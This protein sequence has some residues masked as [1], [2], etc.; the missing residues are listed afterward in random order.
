MSVTQENSKK[1]NIISAP[2]ISRYIR[3]LQS[4][5]TEEN[6]YMAPA[7]DEYSLYAQLRLLKTKMLKK[8]AIRSLAKIIMSPVKY[9]FLF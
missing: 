3:A 9:E 4:L 5:K 2:A 1:V 7:T 8:D 6:E